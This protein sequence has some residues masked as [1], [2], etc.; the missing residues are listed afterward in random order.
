LSLSEVQLRNLEAVKT[1]A[2][3]GILGNWDIVRPFVADDI[4]LHVP[5]CLPW[6]GESHGWEGYQGAL[7][8]M[9]SFFSELEMGPISFSPVDDKVIVTLDLKGTVAKTGKRFAMPLLEVWRVKEER[10]FDIVA[11]FFDTAALVE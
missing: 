2:T 9:G 8:T 5:T 4:V 11:Y 7:L 6:G 1:M 3:N 10:V